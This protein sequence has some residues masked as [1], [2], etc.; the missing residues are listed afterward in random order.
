MNE[1]NC[2]AYY[3]QLSNM[4]FPPDALLVFLI[5]DGYQ[6]IEIHKHMHNTINN[7]NHQSMA[8]CHE[9][10]ANPCH[11]YHA[12]VMKQMQKTDL[13]E[14][15][16]QYKEYLRAYMYVCHSLDNNTVTIGLSTDIHTVSRRSKTL[17]MK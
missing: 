16:P 13:I 17:I 6:I 10:D 15:L 12:S 11:Q 2:F 4:F 1:N 3:L 14:F 5:P 8:A 9:L 7:T